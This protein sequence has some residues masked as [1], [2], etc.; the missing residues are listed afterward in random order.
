[1]ILDFY[2]DSSIHQTIRDT[3]NDMWLIDP[4][5][6]SF[7]PLGLKFG[8]NIDRNWTFLRNEGRSHLCKNQLQYN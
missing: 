5:F 6:C 2:F 4:K 8:I 1:M 3:W 7:Y